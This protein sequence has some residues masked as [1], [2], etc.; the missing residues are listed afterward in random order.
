VH[1]F[2]HPRVKFG[3]LIQEEHPAV[4][5]RDLARVGP[6]A[7][8]HQLD[9]VHLSARRTCGVKLEGVGQN[10]SAAMIAL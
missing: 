5:Q 4:R 10:E 6:V 8:A 3:Q 1:H 9:G 2:Q 7:A